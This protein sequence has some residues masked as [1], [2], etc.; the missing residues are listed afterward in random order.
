MTH[1]LLEL[2][3]KSMRMS[4]DRLVPLLL[5][6]VVTATG[7]VSSS[8]TADLSRVRDLTRP[9]VLAEVADSEVEATRSTDVATMLREPLGPDTAVRIALLN[10]RELRARLREL[11]VER[12]RVIQEGLLPNPRAEVEL[13]PE[14]DSN[15]EV[16]LEYDITSAVLAP[17]RR[18]AAE[19][20]LEAARYRAAGTV[21]QVGYAVRVAFFRLQAA[22][23]R[24]RIA[25]KSLD[26]QAAR[27]DAAQALFDA[28][29]IRE[30]D[31]VS[32][33][34]SYQ[35]ARVTVG[36]L[37]LTAAEQREK[38]VRLMGLHG[39]DVDFELRG[40]LPDAPAELEEAAQ[41]ETRALA[42]SLELREV[43]QRLEALARKTGVTRTAGWLPDI[44]A[45]VHLLTVNPET[46]GDSEV[47]WGGGLSASIP[48]FDRNQGT[49]TALE[50]QFDALL[51]RYYGL[52]I[53]IRSAARDARNRVAAAHARAIHYQKV[54]LPAQ[55]RVTEQM[56]L[57]YNA[58]QI[59]VLD[60]I[61]TRE[62]EMSTRFSYVDALESFWT[63]TA[64]L[65]SLAAGRRVDVGND[66]SA[67]SMS[68]S[69]SSEGNG[70]H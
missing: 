33:D 51:E 20:E 45:D 35:K 1:D 43:R 57:Q 31:L 6:T 36:Q 37:E 52:A 38:L 30:L 2:R 53:D 14:R 58:M 49:V 65:E 46:A 34:A 68:L 21:V 24:L 50:A 59:G 63:A 47:R 13:V 48:I 29:N 25:Q 18:H 44:A 23:Q 56:L 4:T 41:P 11:G 28:G 39:A 17:L 40:D 64:T 26:A 3:R 62:A 66:G 67:S 7:C 10:N 61:R 60:L 55:A 15:V 32:E 69:T 70:D 12:G 8:T 9:P 54:I 19:P 27:R 42:T 16:R 22:A 5:A